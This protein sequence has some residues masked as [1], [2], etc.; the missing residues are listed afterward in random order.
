[1]KV[2]IRIEYEDPTPEDMVCPFCGSEDIEMIGDREY[3][4]LWACNNEH[5]FNSWIERQDYEKRIN[6]DR[7]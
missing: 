3:N 1:M 7:H 2:D 5:E 4:D 6:S